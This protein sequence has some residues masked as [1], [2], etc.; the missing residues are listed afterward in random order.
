[1]SDMR[2]SLHI[3]MTCCTGL[4]RIP[5]ANKVFASG[6]CSHLD[7]PGDSSRSTREWNHSRQAELGPDHRV[8]G[9]IQALPRLHVHFNAFALRRQ[10]SCGENMV[11]APAPV[12]L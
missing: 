8:I 7:P 1:M 2:M 9:S 4:F 6:P 10:G 5:F 12:V 3:T 11:D